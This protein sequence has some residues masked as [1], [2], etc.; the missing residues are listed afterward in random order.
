MFIKGSYS[1]KPRCFRHHVLGIIMNS[2]G[3]KQADV[4]QV[5][6]LTIRYI[7]LM[8]GYIVQMQIMLNACSN[9]KKCVL[10]NVT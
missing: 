1:S 10:T 4:Q 8:K 7:L 3:K 6:K 2:Q 9:E 5:S